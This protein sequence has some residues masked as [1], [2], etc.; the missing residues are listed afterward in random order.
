MPYPSRKPEPYIQTT[1]KEC[2][3]PLEFLPATGVKNTKVEVTCWSCQANLSFEIDAAGTKI[4]PTRPTSK[5]SRKRG[6]G[7]VHLIFC[8][9][10][11]KSQLS[12][13]S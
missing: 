13:Q 5:W 4:K 3:K 12:R 7:K 9:I 1:C 6:T 8:G 2:S 10:L 11:R